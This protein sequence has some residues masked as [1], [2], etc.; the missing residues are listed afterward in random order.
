MIATFD[1]VGRVDLP[2]ELA[3]EPDAV[4]Y[5]PNI[6]GCGQALVVAVLV[7]TGKAERRSTTWTAA[8]LPG[9]AG[10]GERR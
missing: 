6:G 5:T 2:G 10:S 8:R 4:D 9:G 1:F 3:G 7:L